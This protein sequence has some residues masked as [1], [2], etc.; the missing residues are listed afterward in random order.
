[1]V[2]AT[3]FAL[4]FESTATRTIS[5][6]GHT[7][8]PV[9]A[10]PH[11][12]PPEKK[13]PRRQAE[14]PR[15]RLSVRDNK[16]RLLHLL[17]YRRQ[18]RRRRARRPLRTPLIPRRPAADGDKPV[19][20]AGDLNCYPSSSG[21]GVERER[22]AASIALECCGGWRNGSRTEI[23]RCRRRDS[24]FLHPIRPPRRRLILGAAMRIHLVNPSDVSFG[25][26]VITPRWLYVLAAA[27]PARHG[28]PLLDR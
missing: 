1:M 13:R 27:T 2:E 21:T 16:P 17:L 25:T 11:S 7:I 18:N 19:G 15:H 22:R 24:R 26:A 28:T 3:T 6:A 23:Q 10:S 8:A 9:A 5:P 12:N 14:P 4:P 20:Y